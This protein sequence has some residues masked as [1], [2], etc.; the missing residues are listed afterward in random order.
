VLTVDGRSATLDRG[1]SAFVP[2]DRG[3]LALTGGGVAFV[4][5][6]ALLPLDKAR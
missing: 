5:T 1:C 6:T 4:A 3:E 2:A